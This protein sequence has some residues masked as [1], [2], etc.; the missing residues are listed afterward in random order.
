MCVFKSQ[1]TEK[2]MESTFAVIVLFLCMSF[3][4]YEI[5]AKTTNTAGY[6]SS[7]SMDGEFNEL[8]ANELSIQINNCHE[9]CLQ[10]VCMIAP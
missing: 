7:H 5:D 2:K 3:Y 10:K 1:N 4:F 8:T 6:T 9:A